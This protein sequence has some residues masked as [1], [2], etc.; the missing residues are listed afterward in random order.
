MNHFKMSIQTKGRYWVITLNNWTQ[1][2]YNDIISNTCFE[3]YCIGKE[4]GAQGTPHLQCYFVF[5][6]R[7]KGTQIK[8]LKGFA[9]TNLKP[10]SKN[11]THQQCRD[12]ITDNPDKDDAADFIEFGALPKGGGQGR[13]SDLDLVA[14]AITSGSTIREIAVAHPTTFIRY[15]RGIRD[16]ATTVAPKRP[17]KIFDLDSFPFHPIIMEKGYSHLIWGP[18]GCWKTSYCRSLYPDALMVSHIDDL[19]RFDPKEYTAIIFDDMCFTHLPRTAQI[20][21]VDQDDDRSIHCRY[22]TAFIPAGT[23]K[24]FTSNVREIFLMDDPAIK[25]RIKIHHINLIN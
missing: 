18:S 24:V 15:G 25:R 13:R 22:N 2:E 23:I 5:K 10:K 11:S 3:Y 17:K 20:H 14:E 12:Y 7:I 16:L 1:E 9:R 21:L 4:V 6:N 19:L 8:K